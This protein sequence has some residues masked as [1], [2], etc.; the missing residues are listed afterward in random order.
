MVAGGVVGDYGSARFG[1]DGECRRCQMMRSPMLRR[2]KR[3]STKGRTNARRLGSA[4]AGDGFAGLFLERPML[5][6][7]LLLM[8]GEMLSGE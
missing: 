1:D 7:L 5:L 6:P 3:M 4:G 8:G 2:Q